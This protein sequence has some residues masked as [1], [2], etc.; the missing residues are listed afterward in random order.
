MSDTTESSLQDDWSWNPH[1]EAGYQAALL[2]VGA[3][4]MRASKVVGATG[5]KTGLDAAMRACASH[6]PVEREQ[7]FAD[8]LVEYIRKRDAFLRG[9]TP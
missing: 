1:Y 5:Y 2:A 6:W 7:A 3:S 9:E 8:A 4:I